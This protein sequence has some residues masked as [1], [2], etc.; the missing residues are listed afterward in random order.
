MDDLYRWILFTAYIHGPPAVEVVAYRAGTDG[1][2]TV[3]LANVFELYRDVAHVRNF[4]IS[5]FQG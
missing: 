2:E 4:K 1:A 3:L 5:G